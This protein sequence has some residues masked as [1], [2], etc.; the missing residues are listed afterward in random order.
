MTVITTESVRPNDERQHVGTQHVATNPRR[1]NVWPGEIG[2]KHSIFPKQIA[3]HDAGPTVCR[4]RV[5][6]ITSRRRGNDWQR[7]S[8]AVGT[9]QPQISRSK[10]LYTPRQNRAKRQ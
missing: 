8:S 10:A 6:Y 5:R 1:Q 4:H 2:A 3:A 7:F 9:W